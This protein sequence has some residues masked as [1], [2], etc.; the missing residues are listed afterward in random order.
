MQTPYAVQRVL[1]MRKTHL[2]TSDTHLSWEL[3]RSTDLTRS[4]PA[5]K[6]F[7]HFSLGPCKSLITSIWAL[8]TSQ[9]AFL[10]EWSRSTVGS[11]LRRHKLYSQLKSPRTTNTWKFWV[12]LSR[13]MTKSVEIWLPS[14]VVHTMQGSWAAKEQDGCPLAA[15]FSSAPPVSCLCDRTRVAYH[16]Y[17][18]TRQSRIRR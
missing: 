1:D 4:K 17:N 5:L 18:P 14:K 15:G 2:A 3:L 9:S 13:K 7:H 12:L 6:S 16:Y 8:F 10:D 11:S